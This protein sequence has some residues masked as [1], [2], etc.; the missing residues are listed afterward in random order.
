MRILIAEDS[1]V[2][3]RAL[4]RAVEGLGHSAFEA[5]DGEQAWALF[6]RE[7]A[8]VVISDWIMPGIEGPELCR[9]VRAATDRPYTYFVI[10]TVLEEKK[11]ALAGMRA[12]ADDYLTKPV[13]LDE[14]QLRLI[15]AERVAAL[16]RQLAERG[17]AERRASFAAGLDAAQERLRAQVAEMLHGRVQTRL[18]LAYHQLNRAEAAWESDPARARQLVGEARA[19]IDQVREQDVRRA[20]HLLHPLTLREGLAPALASLARELDP[21]VKVDVEVDERLAQGDALPSGPRLAV[22]RIVEEA[23][24]NVVRHAG[25]SAATVRV[26]LREDGCLSLSVRDDGRGFDPKGVEPGLGL[27]AIAARVAEQGGEWR[28]ESAPGR[29]TTV[30]VSLEVT[31]GA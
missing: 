31:A 26:A 20:S 2:M 12:G 25:A 21:Q 8:D 30:S 28:V 16:H 17:A 3:R 5:E 15:A 27:S 10:L 13:D 29:G 22:Y 1:R 4:R 7:G 18:L 24:G 9:R 6:E 23:L 11:H 19:M 14:L